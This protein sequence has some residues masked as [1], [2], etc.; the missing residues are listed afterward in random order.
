[1]VARKDYYSLLGVSK[2]ATEKEIKAAFRKL[3]RKYHPDVNPGDKTAEEKFKQIS[4]AYE[5]LSDAEKRK[6]Y[7]QF[8]DQWQFADQFRQSGAHRTAGPTFQGADFSDIFGG[9]TFTYSSGGVGGG[10]ESLLDELLRGGRG[11]GFSR[12]AQAVRG[13]DI[14][15]PVEISLEE[16]FSGT[17][18]LLSLQAEEV[19][20][21]CRGTGRIQRV[22]CQECQGTGR[23]LRQK[24]IEVKI[25]PG[26]KTGSRVRIAG[27]GGEGQGGPAG[28]LYLLITV[29]PHPLFER[30]GDDIYV[31][32]EVPLT[33]AV[34]GGQVKVHGLKGDLE[35][36]IPPETQN[37]SVFR[38]AGQGMPKLG[39]PNIRGDLRARV[40]V[41]LP[42]NLT[43]EERALFARLRQLRP[44]E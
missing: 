23:V 12:R 16:A 11:G 29:A 27:K 15:H 18:R 38:L 20:P 3:A 40:K 36:K 13:Q 30:Q 37:Q 7:D 9:E 34:L 6:K 25:P 2:S 21:S 26:V 4:E 14:E 44:G 42:S 43:P 19:C 17:S 32:V 10:F 28:D 41:V 8:G 22:I 35:L 24:R 39:K 31:N 1:M 33:T 5:V